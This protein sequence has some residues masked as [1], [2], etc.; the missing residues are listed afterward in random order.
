MEKWINFYNINTD[1][2]LGGYTTEGNFTGELGETIKLLA[3][4]NGIEEFDIVAKVE[5]K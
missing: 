1:E 5:D 3:Y 2:Y 4:E